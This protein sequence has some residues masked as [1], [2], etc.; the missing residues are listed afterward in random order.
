MNLTVRYLYNFLLLSATAILMPLAAD[1][2]YKG[3][4]ANSPQMPRVNQ[5]NSNLPGVYYNQNYY[6]YPYGGY[7]SSY[8]YGQPGY[9]NPGYYNPGIYNI[10]PPT[11]NESFP[12]ESDTD[13]LY[14]YL[15]RNR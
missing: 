8:Y 12:D 10:P 6:N 14:R 5:G 11:P 15:Q 7:G 2:L 9:V 13:S 4:T 1:T 3:D